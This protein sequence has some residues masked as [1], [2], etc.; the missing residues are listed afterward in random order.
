ME[1]S[2]SQLPRA[3]WLRGVRVTWERYGGWRDTSE[4]CGDGVV[5]LGRVFQAASGLAWARMT[6]LPGLSRSISRILSRVWRA[7]LR[8][9]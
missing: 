4:C 7:G 2:G 9:L 6:F 8:G 1:G 5:A 3:V